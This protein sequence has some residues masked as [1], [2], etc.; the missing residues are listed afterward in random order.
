MNNSFGLLR[1]FTTKCHR[2]YLASFFFIFPLSSRGAV[3]GFIYHDCKF[4]SFK[5]HCALDRR[6][7]EAGFFF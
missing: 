1:F 6:L 2:I 4:P 3:F 5:M 7:A